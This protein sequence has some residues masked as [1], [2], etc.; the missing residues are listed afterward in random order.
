MYFTCILAVVSIL[1]CAIKMG[2]GKLKGIAEP[3]SS[4]SPTESEAGDDE[5]DHPKHP[6]TLTPTWDSKF[7]VSKFPDLNNERSGGER[8]DLGLIDFSISNPPRQDLSHG[9]RIT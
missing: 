6:S 7:M 4:S 1:T 3:K 5:A 9:P 8:E 2:G